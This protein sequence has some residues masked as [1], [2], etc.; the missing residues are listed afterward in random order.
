MQQQIKKRRGSKKVKI[1]FPKD[2]LKS[3]KYQ[4]MLQKKVRRGRRWW[5]P[6]SFFISAGHSARALGTAFLSRVC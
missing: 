2:V 6:D 4:S 1:K 3:G 5:T